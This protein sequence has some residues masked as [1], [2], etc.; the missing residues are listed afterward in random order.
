MR[1]N[2][3]QLVQHAFERVPIESFFLFFLDIRWVNQCNFPSCSHFNCKEIEYCEFVQQETL[4]S[5]LELKYHTNDTT[6]L[7]IR[8]LSGM[9]NLAAAFRLCLC[10]WYQLL[11]NQQTKQPASTFPIC[12]TGAARKNTKRHKTRSLVSLITRRSAG[13]AHRPNNK[14]EANPTTFVF[15]T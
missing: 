12:G 4:L 10:T 9:Y 6:R 1:F 13:G 8:S 15:K 7:Q 14:G 5:L 2:T 11:N 3:A